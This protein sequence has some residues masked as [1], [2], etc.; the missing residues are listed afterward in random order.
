MTISMNSSRASVSTPGRDASSHDA[1][2][3]GAMIRAIVAGFALTMLLYLF[4]GVG[5]NPLQFNLAPFLIIWAYMS[6]LAAFF[7]HRD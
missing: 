5:T 1:C 7:I 4:G 2:G 6:F 3:R